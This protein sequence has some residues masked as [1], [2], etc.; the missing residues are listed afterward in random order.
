LCPPG[1]AEIDVF[2]RVDSS[3]RSH[4][5]ALHRNSARVCNVPDQFNDNHLT[6]DVG[7]DLASGFHTYEALWTS[8]TVTWYIDGRE[9]K[10]APVYDSTDQEMFIILSIGLGEWGSPG[11]APAELETEVDWVRVWQKSP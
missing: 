4:N 2:E 9:L 8:S 1:A 7:T 11:A 3:V 10:H 6:S 5:G